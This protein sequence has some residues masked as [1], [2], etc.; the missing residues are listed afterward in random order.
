LT[1]IEL[2]IFSTLVGRARVKFSIQAPAT[3]GNPIFERYHRVH[4]NTLEQ[5]VVFL[6]LLWIFAFYVHAK[7]AA[8]LGVLFIV[9]RI[10]YAM[11]YV[12]E[13]SRRTAGAGLTFVVIAVLAL[14]SLIGGLRAAF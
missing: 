14:G 4:Q 11:G 2:M 7:T 9:A 10:V 1:L 6:P 5:V 12:K 13:P 3:S 8:A